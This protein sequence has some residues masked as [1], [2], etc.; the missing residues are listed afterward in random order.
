MLKILTSTPTFVTIT[1]SFTNSI[2]NFLQM[3]DTIRFDFLIYDA[4]LET[5]QHSCYF[6]NKTHST[7]LV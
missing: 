7:S 6:F 2:P 3:L 4:E 5:L 1:E